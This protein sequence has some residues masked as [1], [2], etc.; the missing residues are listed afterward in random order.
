VTIVF[1]L[2][3]AA[4]SER[5]A[6]ERQI[7]Y[8]FDSSA[9]VT[10]DARGLAVS[11]MEAGLQ[12]LERGDKVAVVPITG[13]VHAET[14]GRVLRFEL[15]IRRE[16]YDTDRRRLADEV[17]RLLPEFLASVKPSAHTD[18]LSTFRLAA[19]ELNAA[20]VRVLVCLSDFV[21][22]D[23]QFN[24]KTDR[25]LVSERSATTFAQELA[26]DFAGRFRGVHVYL[27]LM[28]SVDLARL[29]N[30][31]RTAIQTFWLEFFEAQGASVRWVTDGAGHL[32]D[33]LKNRGN[34]ER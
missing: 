1:A 20:P 8:V 17:H 13:D 21:Q 10:A 5:S 24:F 26:D 29:S 19:E 2:W 14:L 9:S 16:P 23:S 3:T 25:R 11:S 31:R 6:S 7:V 34:F 32:A 30:P 18:M 33:F 28:Q 12:S 4:C 22:D 15:S 27:G